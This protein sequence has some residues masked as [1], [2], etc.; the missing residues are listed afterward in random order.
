[1]IE[2]MAGS[3]GQKDYV[4][5]AKKDD[6]WLGLKMTLDVVM[7]PFTGEPSISLTLSIR[8]AW[9]AAKP[10]VEEADLDL[11]V[12]WP[13]I[14]FSAIGQG[15]ASTHFLLESLTVS[16]SS[17][18]ML[19]EKIADGTVLMQSVNPLIASLDKSLVVVDVANLL[20]HFQEHLNQ[21]IEELKPSGRPI[22]TQTEALSKFMKSKIL[23]T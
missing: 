6:I 2:Y 13:S 3:G 17:F 1:M 15:R 19:R 22:D 8:S 20:D 7:N 18:D 21:K 23:L 9:G 4:V 11:V 12:P 14:K 5:V 10:E 16:V